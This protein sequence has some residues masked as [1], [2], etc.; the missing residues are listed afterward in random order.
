MARQTLAAHFDTQSEAHNAADAAVAAGLSRDNIHLNEHAESSSTSG[1]GEK[2]R[3]FWDSIT[4]FFMPDDDRYAYDEGVRR[5]G[6]TLVVSADEARVDE[7]AEILEQNGAVDLDER[8]APGRTRAGRVRRPSLP[9]VGRWSRRTWPA[10]P[11]HR[12]PAS[13][14]GVAPE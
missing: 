2:H 9:L 8:R 12:R 1:A 10:A 5:G 7:V 6:A 14:P 4:D 3:G 11:R 13:T